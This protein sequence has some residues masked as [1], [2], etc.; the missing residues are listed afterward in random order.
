V[1]GA[2]NDMISLVAN[3]YYYIE[4]LSLNVFMSPVH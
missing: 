3:I 4:L 1:I 2:E